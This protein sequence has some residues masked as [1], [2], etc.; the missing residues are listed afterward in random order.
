MGNR[1]VKY[2]LAIFDNHPRWGQG[3]AALNTSTAGVGV[4]GTVYR[5]NS[6]KPGHGSLS[7]LACPDF[8]GWTKGLNGKAPVRFPE[9]YA[10][11]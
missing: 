4:A 9:G 3:P 1:V 7:P 8:S 2:S 5:E 11:G 10:F 6:T